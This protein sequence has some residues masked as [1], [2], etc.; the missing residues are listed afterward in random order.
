M[1]KITK[2]FG[3]L[4]AITAFLGLGLQANAQMLDDK[5]LFS[6]K[7]TGAQETPS[8]TTNALGVAS[9]TLNKT[10]DTMCVL[11][12]VNGLSG[13]ITGAHV[14]TGAVGV[15][16]GVVTALPATGT[17]NQIFA[18]LTGTDV[19]AA[20]IQKYLS[21]LMYVNV[22]TAANPNGEIRGQ[23]YLETDYSYVA[24]ATGAQETPSVTTTAYGLGVFNLAQHDSVLMYHVIAQGLSG[25]ITGAHLHMGAP[26][27][28]GGV[29]YDMSPNIMGN[30]ISGT[31]TSGVGAFLASLKAGNI[32][33]NIHTAANPNGEI[34]GQLWKDNSLYFDAN[35]NGPQDGTTAMGTGVVSMKLNTTFDTLMYNVVADNL[36]GAITGMHIHTGAFGTSGGVLVSLNSSSTSNQAT[37]FVTGA[38]LTPALISGLI[39]GSTYVNIHTAANPNGEIRGQIYRLARQGYNFDMTGAQQ[40]PTPVV[41]SAYGSGIV[42]VD[43]NATNAHVMV[44]VGGLSGAETGVH[45]HKG[46]AN[47]AG[48]VLYDLST[49][50]AG[51][52][53]HDAGFGYLKSSDASPFTMQAAMSM[54]HDSTYINLHTTANANGE[55]RGNIMHGS[56]CFAAPTG[57]KQNSATANGTFEMYP[58]PSSDMITIHV[59]ANASLSETTAIQVYNVVGQKVMEQTIAGTNTCTLNVSALNSGIYIVRVYNGTQQMVKQLIKN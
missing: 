35:M 7:M 24:N 13:A 29:V 17:S 4:T 44:V 15:G 5:L 45:I 2:N 42:S 56:A 43:R 57:I 8:V 50:F 49:W 21:G 39:N 26:G 40:F 53:T 52:G 41:T 22:H 14:H 16:G 19:S 12:S 28:G 51:T 30:T 54:F 46:A 32:Y 6:A 1:K 38:N 33:F 9:F 34:R 20:N 48:G 23:V 31:I 37:G 59:A 55:I 58:N 27:V 25:A 10:R 47:Q 3:K 36:T 18:T 11:V